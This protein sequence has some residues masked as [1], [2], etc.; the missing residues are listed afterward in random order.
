MLPKRA[1]T[2]VNRLKSPAGFTLVEALIAVALLAIVAVGISAPYISGF[3]ALDVQAESMLLDS[4]L[5]SRMEKL[6]S[7]SFGSLSSGSELVTVNGQDFN[8]I[9]TVDPVDLNGDTFMEPTAMKVTV[10]VTEQPNHSLTTIRV[11]NED[12]V[13]KVS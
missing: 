5:R 12:K 11:H 10:S 13:G 6:V 1:Y 9:W 8:I 7:T 3:Q 2:F 4:R